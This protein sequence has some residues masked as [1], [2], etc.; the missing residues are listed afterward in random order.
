[1]RVVFV[2]PN[3]GRQ[4]EVRRLLADVDV[5][6][7]RLG[8]TVP[9]GLDL[10]DTA[11]ARAAGAFAQLGRP[12]FVENTLFE[13]EDEPPLRGA[14]WKERF[15]ALGEEGFCRQ[16]AGRRCV[17][18][19]VVALA[20]GPS[21]AAVRLFAGEI[22]GAFSATPRGEGGYGWDRV[23]IPDGYQ[24]TLAELDTSKYLVNMRHAPYLDLAD[25]LRGRSFGGAFEAHVTVRL[26]DAVGDAPRFRAACDRLGVKCMMIEL[27]EGEHVAQP[28]TA[29]IHRGVLRE[30]QDEV[31]GL[32]RE[33][34]AAGFVIVRTKVEALPRNADIP[35]DDAQAARFPAG[36]FEFHVKLL[37]SGGA[38]ALEA[39][40]VACAPHG[41]RLSKNANKRR[42]DGT[43]ERFVTLRVHRLGR[44]HAEERFVALEAA[45]V[46]L[47]VPMR[48]RIREYTVYDSNVALDR[49]W[50]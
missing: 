29:S 7:S 32:A 46:A 33:L 10:E 3:Q 17:A 35:E 26:A 28:M 41:A 39:V 18:R 2:T 36:Y 37:L 40:R 49:G 30:V 15:A 6:L 25:Y 43:E 34:I 19:V 45:L 16:Y 38:D 31:H 20:E 44:A 24:R 12:C 27:P 11:R 4:A 8:P 13:L 50:L 47:G 42:D 9:D 5:E 21:V 23:F 48:G 1:M 14:A 22:S